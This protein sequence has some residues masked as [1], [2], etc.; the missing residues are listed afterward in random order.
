[1]SRKGGGHLQFTY[2][3]RDN[4]GHAVE[5]ALE[6]DTKQLAIERLRQQ[7]LIPIAI[8]EGGAAK[9]AGT[10][11]DTTPKAKKITVKELSLLSRQLATMI[12][13]GLPLVSALNVLTSQLDKKSIAAVI[14]DVRKRVE[15]GESFSN[16]IKNYP[17]I[18]PP[19]FTNLVEAG[20]TAGALNHVLDRTARYYENSSR[21]IGKVKSALSYPI[22]LVVVAILAVGILMV[23][24]L[25]S[26]ID[27]FESFDAELPTVTKIVFGT[28]EFIKDKWYML[29]I[30]AAALFFF[31]RWLITKP[32]KPWF[33]TITLRIP[34]IGPLIK[35][36]NTAVFSRTFAM[37]VQSG[38]PMLQGLELMEK[39]AGNYVMRK[40]IETAKLGVKEG[41]GLGKPLKQS[42]I[43]PPMLGHM[44]AIG[45]ETGAL[46]SMLEKVADFYDEE[47]DM[48]IKAL[49]SMVEPIMILF[50]GVLAAFLVAAIMVPMF[51]IASFVQ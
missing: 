42:T 18:F 27:L 47:T 12:Q 31:I 16:A 6:A 4:K 41:S 2:K 9:S 49:T 28:A 21:N 37:M 39:T 43:F 30:I 32:L 13:A 33:D 25:P 36:S 50:I 22:F 3:A 44:V 29:I 23:A 5:G 20:E 45:E 46:D 34:V 24:V 40:N 26:F 14:N 51:S 35:K 15:G 11:L 19:M 48:A 38:V 17:G 8:N 1:M 10:S 7:G